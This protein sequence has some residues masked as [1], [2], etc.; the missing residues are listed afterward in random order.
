MQPIEMLDVFWSTHY[1]GTHRASEPGAKEC[2]ESLRCYVKG[3][4]AKARLFMRL[5]N[6]KNSLQYVENLLEGICPNVENVVE[7]ICPNM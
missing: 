1:K 3:K 5:D 6:P 2:G 7:G 4:S